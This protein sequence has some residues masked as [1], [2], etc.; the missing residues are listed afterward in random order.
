M[1]LTGASRSL[2]PCQ[3]DPADVR[4]SGLLKDKIILHFPTQSAATDWTLL[5]LA[6]KQ[7]KDF[8]N[9]WERY[10]TEQG[11]DAPVEPALVVQVEN[12]SGKDITRTDLTKLVSV[13][14]RGLGKLDDGA[15]VHCFQEGDEWTGDGSTAGE[16]RVH[17]A[18]DRA[19]LGTGHP[20]PRDICQLRQ[21]PVS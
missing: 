6:T 16:T 10:C 4:K 15:V 7:L 3:I 20:D 13:L 9:R 2:H 8:D 14:E 5:E 1:K 18:G 17:L 12:E 19:W 21:P 11:M